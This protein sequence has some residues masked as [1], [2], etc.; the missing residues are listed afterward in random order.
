MENEFQQLLN[1]LVFFIFINFLFLIFNKKISKLVNINDQPDSKRK[2]HRGNPS[3][4]GGIYLFLNI[5]LFYFIV[6]SN[7]FINVTF[8]P[9]KDI[10]LLISLILIFLIGIFDDKY[11]LKAN[12]KLALLC[13]AVLVSIT[14]TIILIENIQF[15]SFK[16][17][18]I[19]IISHIFL[20]FY[21][22]CC[23]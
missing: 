17:I 12:S 4:I 10:S 18:Y 1:F 15:T 7:Y 23:L 2:L 13:I 9:F 3:L 16:E 21:V 19:Y 14:T 8:F 5:I 11:D 6:K 20:L 22:F